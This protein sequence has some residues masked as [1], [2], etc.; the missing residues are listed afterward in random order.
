MYNLNVFGYL[1]ELLKLLQQIVFVELLRVLRPIS[2]N[3]WCFVITTCADCTS[4]MSLAIHGVFNRHCAYIAI[5]IIPTSTI[6]SRLQLSCL[7]ALVMFSACPHRA[8]VTK[9]DI[10]LN[11]TRHSSLNVR[12]N[13]V[14]PIVAALSLFIF[15]M[16]L[17]NTWHWTNEI[18]V[19]AHPKNRLYKIDC[20]ILHGGKRSKLYVIQ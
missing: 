4:L 2:H 16:L 15:C 5:W 17:R 9:Q 13:R 3:D 10:S 19:N 20:F 14:L 12:Q 6:W 8:T 11:K 18:W 7:R 1:L